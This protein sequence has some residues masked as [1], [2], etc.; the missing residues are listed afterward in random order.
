MQVNSSECFPN[1][2]SLSIRAIIQ[3]VALGKI[4]LQ[5]LGGFYINDQKHEIE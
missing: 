1:L 4:I 5:N 2:R 3:D